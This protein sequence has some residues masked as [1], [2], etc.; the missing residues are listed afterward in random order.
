MLQGEEA[1]AGRDLR[2]ADMSAERFHRIPQGKFITV[3]CTDCGNKQTVF[4]KATSVVNCFVC[5]TTLAKPTGGKADI[6][7]EVT[8]VLE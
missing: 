1:G 5:G 6:K 3:K 7:G 4:E 8:G 2:Y